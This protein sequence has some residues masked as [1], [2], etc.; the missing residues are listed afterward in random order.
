MNIDNN[1]NNGNNKIWKAYLNHAQAF[2]KINP[3]FSFFIISFLIE[4][5]PLEKDKI[6]KILTIKQYEKE[7][8]QFNISNNFKLTD[9]IT[10]EEYSSIIENILDNVNAEEK[11]EKVSYNT[12][13][14]F[15]LIAD[16]LDIVVIYEDRIDEDEGEWKTLSKF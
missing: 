11:S 6:N 10:Y 7:K 2:K 3:K 13:A 16:L 4:K 14:V 1:D 12:A 15:R 8:K 5:I 9:F